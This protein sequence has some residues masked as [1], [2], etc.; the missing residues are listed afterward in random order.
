M[1]VDGGGAEKYRAEMLESY[2]LRV[3]LQ[4]VVVFFGLLD[5]LC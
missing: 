5:L 1:R 2:L 4:Y 3:R